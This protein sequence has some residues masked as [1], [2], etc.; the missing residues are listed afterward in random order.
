MG[1][2]VISRIS[3]SFKNMDELELAFHEMDL[4]G[5]GKITKDEMMKYGSLNE[6]EVNAVFELGDVDRDGT[7]DIQEFTGVMT[8]CSPVP[9]VEAGVTEQIGDRQV[10][11]VGS[12]PKCIVWCHD[13]R[14]FNAG[15][16]TRQ[17]VDKLAETTGWTVVLPDFI[18][19]IR[20]YWVERLWP[21][22]RD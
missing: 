8:S 3:S 2:T 1:T 10:D 13:M 21:F 5:D 11:I 15:D 4:D 19:D 14:G 7:I 9:Y 18:G 6:Q 17:L 20:D 22:L 16:R 12:S